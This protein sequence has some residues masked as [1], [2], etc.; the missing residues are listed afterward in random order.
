MTKIALI[1]AGSAV[2]SLNLVKDI[3][4]TPNLQD[5]TI[6]FMDV[7]ESRLNSI[8]RLCERYANEA[9]I[10]LNL[11]KSTDRR[12]ALKG[13]DFV[14]NTA[15][16]AGHHRLREGWSIAKKYG[17]RFGGSLHVMHD[18]AFWI[19]FYQFGLM[20]DILK[21]VLE[22]S[23]SAW[24]L[25]VANPVMGGTT[26]LKRKYPQANIVGLCHGFSGVY[27]I[28]DELGLQRDRLTFEV[29][30]INHFIWLTEFHYEGK[31][32]K[33]LI[34]QWI[35]EKSEAYFESCNECDQMGPKAVDLYKRFGAFPI[36]DT[37]SPGGGSW[38][39]W[40]HA[41]DTTEERYKE[42]PNGWYNRYFEFAQHE[43]SEIQ[44]YSNDSS[45]RLMDIFQSELS[46]ESMIP[47]IESIACDIPRV[48]I[49][50]ILNDGNYVPGIPMD[51]EVEVPALCSRR[52]VQGIRTNGLPKPL[53]SYALSD[54]VAPV[55]MEL[56]AFENRDREALLQLILMDPWTVSEDQAQGLIHD[57]MAL[58]YHEQ[59]KIHFGL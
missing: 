44:R 37:G 35:Y 10:K 17:Y 23:P 6:H 3:C 26:Y 50:N 12:E 46:G 39:W 31:D 28:A 42:N 4:L 34:D 21:D 40:Y 11:E 20:E 7:D 54:R 9:G 38:G 55:E 41:D 1:G 15:L 56:Q 19:N 52:G 33:P 48:L 45:I 25:L 59:M 47:L 13:A 58:P 32:A 18:E 8:F 5:S 36:G 49:V 51:F 57:I 43:V 24:Y 30:G 53:I 16:T 29:P 27:S 14:I 2:F 22:I